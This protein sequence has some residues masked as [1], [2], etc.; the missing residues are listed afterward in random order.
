MCV[1]KGGEKRDIDFSVQ[2]DFETPLSDVSMAALSD[3][4]YHKFSSYIWKDNQSCLGTI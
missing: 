4:R 3:L 2:D 1:G